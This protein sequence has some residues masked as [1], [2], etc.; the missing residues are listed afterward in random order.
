MMRC[1]EILMETCENS[2]KKRK[3]SLNFGIIF[4]KCFIEILTKF[5]KKFQEKFVEISEI[6]SRMNVTKSIFKFSGNFI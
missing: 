5:L 4:K 1:E 3:F 2:R 6:L